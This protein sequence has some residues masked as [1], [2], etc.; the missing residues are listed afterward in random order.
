MPH[1]VTETNKKSIQILIS[2][3]LSAIT[4][5]PS[6]FEKVSLSPHPPISQSPHPPIPLPLDFLK[7]I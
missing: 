2:H 4:L 1:L 3:L 5:L 6:A 7:K